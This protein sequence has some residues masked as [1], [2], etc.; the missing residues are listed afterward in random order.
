[1]KEKN[2]NFVKKEDNPANMPEIRQ[3]EDFWG[4]LKGKVYQNA[5]QAKNLNQLGNRIKYCLGK[6]DHNIVYDRCRSTRSRLN[7]IRINGIIENN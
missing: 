1:M 3:I 2:V 5:W 6:L 7:N 4:I